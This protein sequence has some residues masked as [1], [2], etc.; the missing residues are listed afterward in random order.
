MSAYDGNRIIA[1]NAASYAD[2]SVPSERSDARNI[3]ARLKQFLTEFRVR[4]EFVYRDKLRE[5][6]ALKLFYL[7]VDTQDLVLYSDD[8][9]SVIQE[10]PGEILPL[11]ENAAVQVAR[12]LLYPNIV[13]GSVQE[14]QDELARIIPSIQ[15]MLRSGQNMT[16]F[17][18]LT[19]NT[20]SRLVRIPGIVVSVSVLASRATKLHLMCRACRGTK[21]LYPQQGLGGIGSGGDR[22]LPRVCDAP[23][24]EG[25]KKDCPMDPY[26]IV[27]ERCLFVDHQ[28]IKLQEPPDMVPVGELPRHML[29]SADRYL[30]SRVVPGS[31][32]IA[33]GIYSTYQAAKGRRD[34]ASAPALRSAYLRV[35]GLDTST[36]GSPGGGGGG[37]FGAQFTAADE[38][39]FR[40]LAR[41][42]G[43]YEKFARSVA[44]SIYGS[45]DIKKA[46]TCLLFGGSKRIL[47]DNMH[48]R[49][50]INV[51]LLGD[52]GTAKSQ[53]LKFVEK[54]S[55]ISVY[56]SGKGS[57]AAGLTAAV[58]RDPI[59]REFFLEGGAMVLADGGV[60]CIDEFDKMRDED[61]VAIH[62]AMEQQTISVAKA[63]I[64]TVLNSRTS[65]LAAAN[66]V[67]GRYDEGRSP[68][69]NIDF[70][71]TIL[72]RFDMIFIVRDE[73][74]ENR[75]K[76]IAKHVMNI[77]M[78]RAE[79][80]TDVE[81][82]IDLDTMRR[83]VAFCKQTCAPRLSPES[84]E[85][86]SSHFVGL[87][88]EVQQVERDNNER[89]SIPITIRQLEAI[90]RISEALA[91]ITL[92][93]VVLP[94]HVEEAIRLFKSSTM[95]AV[96]AGS[97]DG[98]SRGE[99]NEEVTKIDKEL[100]RRLPVGWST[101]YQS[102]V[103]EFV[104]QQGFSNHALE[105]ALYILE[106]REVIRYTAQRKV[107]NRI[108]FSTHLNIGQISES[109]IMHSRRLVLFSVWSTLCKD[110]ALASYSAFSK[111]VFQ[112]SPTEG[113]WQSYSFAP[114]S[115]VQLP[116]SV[117]F[118]NGSITHA[119]SIVAPEPYRSNL[120][121]TQLHGLSAALTLDFGKNI[122]GIP[123]ITFG[124]ESQPGEVFGMAF[125][126]SKQFISR[127]S[128]RAMDFF[129]DDGALFH[130]IKPGGAEE[131]TPQYRHMRGAFRYMTL[132]LN[133][134]GTVSITNVRCFNNMMPHW[135]NLRNYGGFFYSS[136]D[137][138][139]NIWYA[140]A[141]TIQLSTIPPNTGRG[142]DHFMER[143]GYDNSA[144]AG[145]GEAVLT[146]GAR[147]DRTV[148]AG[149]R[150][151][152][153]TAQHYTLNDA[154]S[155]QTGLEWL[156]AQQDP[157]TG[158]MPYAAPPIDE[159]GSDTYHLWSMVVLYDTYFYA[160]G[161]KDWLLKPRRHVSGGE[162][163]LWQGAQRAI[164]F[165]IRKL[166]GGPKSQGKPGLLWVDHKLDW[167]RVDQGGYNLAANC[168]FVRA[169]QRMAELG[170]ELGEWDKVPLWTDLANSVKD[171]I[172]FKLW[173]DGR[174]S[175]W[176]SVTDSQE[177]A[178]RVS[179]GLKRNWNDFGTV[180]PESPGMISTFIS[181]FE[182]LAHFEAGEAQRAL[183]L[184]HLLWCYVWNSP[185]GVQS[186]LIEGYYK[187]GRCYYPFQ[188]Y[189]PSYISHAHP[190]AS[191]PSIV[192]SRNVVGLRFTNA[193]HT[194]W[195]VIPEAK[196]DL[197]YAVAGVSSSN[198][199][200]LT[201]G[202]SKTSPWS[203]E[204]AI[205]APA[206]THGVVGVPV[207]WN[208]AQSYEVRINGQKIISGVGNE[209]ASVDSFGKVTPRREDSHH[210]MIE[211]LGEGNHFI[212]VV[213][214]D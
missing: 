151:I 148:W 122:A 166:N 174:E 171:A 196:V 35:C 147:R 202:W 104:N 114:E 154:K 136:D 144:P 183:D 8:L 56:T 112:A 176:F 208:E 173:D 205:K 30:T 201:S 100:R 134:T 39:A 120:P 121:P 70:Q 18:D 185:Y 44:P 149:D 58:Q 40:A 163:S 103:K 99:M 117:L 113:P 61:R 165:S 36:S 188:A 15:I 41:T 83:Y 124:K 66:P 20:F 50:D 5:N 78:D 25:Q 65:V 123:T 80:E 13:Q 54:A 75:D 69:E 12:Q 32:I 29:L 57:S 194:T 95:D 101:S 67:F 55:P 60:V 135:E 209:L 203:L 137:F 53:L 178:A 10:K 157:L 197:D 77:H 92:S 17:R 211:D 156:F 193:E 23:A 129:V 212:L 105:R 102:L 38:V 79:D 191:G 160:G 97:T 110:S 59:S 48:L 140:G 186:S 51:L 6:V 132:F 26:Q 177:K 159:W 172:N 52:P 74:N 199:Q 91:K 14:K 170:Q 90:T 72:S 98:L 161:D 150:A 138:L 31:R 152:S 142:H 19:A 42:E 4:N 180:A 89:S 198:G 125:A 62:E 192:L 182:L 190:W 63:G 108:G 9:A 164:E 141:Y 195:S 94:N 189:D 106:K 210:L 96:A 204:L 175:V 24:P 73:H 34:V 3:E 158:Q 88:K 87:R 169:L 76:A 213:F 64:T 28:T 167:G 46:I 128:D 47:P 21:I 111:L 93:P 133:S 146:D 82:E 153:T 71:T 7:E 81:G 131:W 139:N 118:A 27:H 168:I 115:R 43:L 45:L 119:N 107:I 68:G 206:G 37:S 109:P 127:T 179:S 207:L 126:E 16:S 187:D 143:Y 49:G 116:V 84:A 214:N 1:V 85:L 155:S 184:I 11:F 181:G 130:T 22:G 86:L 2:E 200:L 162:V 33:T 145:T